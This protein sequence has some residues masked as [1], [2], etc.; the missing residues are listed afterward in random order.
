MKE[1]TQR[2]IGI[3]EEIEQ[4]A[5]GHYS[6]GGSYSTFSVTTAATI[7]QAAIEEAVRE[8]L[9]KAAERA[10]AWYR[11]GQLIPAHLESFSIKTLRTTILGEEV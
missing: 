6:G 4:N 8:A 2:A 10:V 9:E 11:S 5:Y 1:P 3:A 7:I